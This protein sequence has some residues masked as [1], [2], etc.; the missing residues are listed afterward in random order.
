MIK[1]LLQEDINRFMDDGYL[2]VKNVFSSELAEKINLMVWE[3]LIEK[4]DDPTTWKKPLV[5]LREVFKN[6]IVDQIHTKKYFDAID[7][8]CGEGRW[9]AHNGAGVWPIL[10]PG[11]SD[12]WHVP[13]E[14]W[15][16]EGNWFHHH[17]NSS[18]QGLI[19]IQLFTDIELGGGGTGIRPGSHYYTAQVLAEAEPD[20]LDEHEL[21][22][23]VIPLT[24]HLPVVELTGK[25]GDIVFIHPFT[26]HGS[27][28]NLSK[29]VRIA[30]NKCISLYNPLNLERVA[31]ED[32]SPVEMAII[33]AL[34]ENRVT[35]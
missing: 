32:Y 8:L 4:P 28:T 5:W 3:R 13:D 12:T 20:G 23:R 35:M 18:E 10:F 33:N 26:L 24:K 25:T 11:F 19:G 2:V 6:E 9:F 14:N 7:D 22:R 21:C 34:K 31:R 29:K 30:A 1:T 17:I 15:H 16:I 27:S